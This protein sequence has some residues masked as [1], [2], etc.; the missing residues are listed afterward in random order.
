M[1]DLRKPAHR[2]VVACDRKIQSTAVFF[3]I[4]CSLAVFIAATFRSSVFQIAK[5]FPIAR[6]LRIAA[7]RQVGTPCETSVLEPF[8]SGSPL[9]SS[10]SSLKDCWCVRWFG[11][12][13][14][15]MKQGGVSTGNGR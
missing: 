12:Q 15:F 3:V 6:L 13:M 5:L 10:I 8:S 2:C 14:R 9:H 11:A 4:C 7:F 1:M